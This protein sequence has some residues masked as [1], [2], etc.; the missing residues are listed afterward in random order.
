MIAPLKI[1]LLYCND[2]SI[3]RFGDARKE[4][5]PL[6]LLYLASACENCNI[7]VD[8]YNIATLTA[9]TLPFYKIIGLSI[10]SSY[11]YP[12]FKKKSAI[13]RNKC[14]YLLV[15]GQ[16]T[17]L[18]PKETT[19]DLCADFALI[20]EGEISLPK[21]IVSLYNNLSTKIDGVYTKDSLSHYKYHEPQRI[22]ALDSLPFPA[23][24][25]LPRED[26]MLKNRIPFHD[27]YST[28]I[29]TSRGCPHNCQFC[30]N[31]YK[32]FFHR[33]GQN[34]AEEI[35]AL[36]N[37][38]PEIQ[39]LIFMDENLFFSEKHAHDI[40]TCMSHFDLKWTCNARA[41]NVAQK[42]LPHLQNSG[43]VE[44]KYG[45]ESGCQEILDSMRKG[46]TIQDIE[47]TLKLTTTFGINTKCFLMFGYPGDSIETALET[48]D[49]LKRNSAYI[50]RVNLFSFS[51]LPGSPIFQ[52]GSF[53]VSSWEDFKIYHQN[54]HWWGTSDEY[55]NMI[56]GYQLLHN[57]I[58]LV[59]GNI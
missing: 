6:G 33:S 5:P 17:T 46:I 52:K 25:L 44:I 4:F 56:Q 54:N 27:I 26:I 24:H 47:S 32:K 28:T 43:C 9:E 45:I 20:G 57:Y 31:V 40:I 14:K 16:H 34:V 59:Y 21:L 22:T 23:R 19:H 18:F 7:Q 39:G 53:P 35:H 3:A 15:G 37:R 41:D 49:F 8:I 50:S 48:I 12:T 38:Y 51:P 42:V 55:Y 29:I 10:N 36:Q 2:S 13:F 11:V 1:A 58:T 30:G